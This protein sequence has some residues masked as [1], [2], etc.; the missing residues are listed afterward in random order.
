[1]KRKAQAK[2]MEDDESLLHLTKKV[3]LECIERTTI[4]SNSLS[5]WTNP[6]FGSHILLTAIFHQLEQGEASYQQLDEV[7][8]F[9][10]RCIDKLTTTTADDDSGGEEVSCNVMDGL[11]GTLQGIFFIRRELQRP[12]WAKKEAIR[13]ATEILLRGSENSEARLFTSSAPLFWGNLDKETDWT[14]STGC[15][16]ILQSLLGLEI[17]EWNE[18]EKTIPNALESLLEKTIHKLPAYG[19]MEYYSR[20]RNKSGWTMDGAAG[21]AVLLLQSYVVLGSMDYLRQAQVLVRTKIL[22]WCSA[23]MTDRSMLPDD[24]ILGLFDG[25]VGVCYCLWLSKE[26]HTAQKLIN[27]AIAHCKK[28]IRTSTPMDLSLANG[29]SGLVRLLQQIDN[30]NRDE[31]EIPFLSSALFNFDM[32]IQMPLHE[33]DHDSASLHARRRKRNEMK[34][35]ARRHTSLPTHS[36]ADSSGHMRRSY[37]LTSLSM[38]KRWTS[39]SDLDEDSHLSVSSFTTEEKPRIHSSIQFP[40]MRAKRRPSNARSASS[41]SYSLKEE[42][43]NALKTRPGSSEPTTRV[44]SDDESSS[45]STSSHMESA[46]VD[47]V[48]NPHYLA[49]QDS[50]NEE[51]INANV[52]VSLLPGKSF[53]SDSDSSLEQSQRKRPPIDRLALFAR[54][55]NQNLNTDS[56]SDSIIDNDQSLSHLKETPSTSNRKS[57]SSHTSSRDTPKDSA[58]SQTMRRSLVRSP[59]PQMHTWMTA[60]K[61]NLMAGIEDDAPIPPLP[62]TSSRSS[63]E[64]L[65]GKRDSSIH[66]PHASNHSH[67]STSE[68]LNDDDYDPNAT[69]DGLAF[70]KPDEMPDQNYL[71]AIDVSSRGGSRSVFA[72]YKPNSTQ[73]KTLMDEECHGF[74]SVPSNQYPSARFIKEESLQ[75]AEN[76]SGSD[77]MHDDEGTVG[78]DD[79]AMGSPDDMPSAAYLASHDVSTRTRTYDPMRNYNP[80]PAQKKTLMDEEDHERGAKNKK[81]EGRMMRSLSEE[82]NESGS[83][84]MNDDDD[85]TVEGDGLALGLPDELPS[86]AYLDSHDVSTRTR[87]YDPFTNYK[88]VPAQKKT[89]MDEEG[90]GKL[91]LPSGSIG[92]SS[93]GE[94]IIHSAAASVDTDDGDFEDDEMAIGL[95]NEVPNMAY[96]DTHDISTRTRSYDPYVNY[97]PAKAQQKTLMDEEGHGEHVSPD[98]DDE[99]RSIESM[100]GEFDMNEKPNAEY[101]AR[102]DSLKEVYFD[103]KSN[104][105]TMPVH[106]LLDEEDHSL[107]ESSAPGISFDSFVAEEAEKDDKPNSEYLARQDSGQNAYFEIPSATT[108]MPSH[109][110]DEA[111]PKELKKSAIEAEIE[112]AIKNEGE[113]NILQE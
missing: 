10:D 19:N 67:E 71:D 57:L 39:A 16:G 66:A 104:T 99:S 73:R 105:T 82:S 59:K 109:Q 72:Q 46:T 28:Q 33:G 69:D 51:Y 7:E 44:D 49:K 22:P 91:G 95:P 92:A 54:T 34:Q 74:S 79:L 29:V 11:A 101:L 24:T 1:M 48:A 36:H 65:R 18:I 40:K 84:S 14:M 25:A 12:D 113:R 3:V 106:N 53:D 111:D 23:C 42:D 96:L 30:R 5:V 78:D 2:N 110:S 27:K 31:V 85:D 103:Y 43:E 87:A 112:E 93:K 77:S 80:V 56:D 9:L 75:E 26:K 76:E 86:A 68:S 45:F 100:H 21:H 32:E 20:S 63:D 88:P 55:R 4:E 70:G 35:M 41:T 15:A 52:S 8:D 108:K 94:S 47:D 62:S 50:D 98:A 37:P 97:R 60:S 89:L 17:N 102:Q 90:H 58:H 83:D 64:R 6:S 13:I 61:R 38:S 107:V 81:L